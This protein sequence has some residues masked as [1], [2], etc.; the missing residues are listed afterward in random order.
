MK[1]PLFS[2]GILSIILLIIVCLTIGISYQDTLIIIIISGVV[3]FLLNI[4]K[5]YY[6]NYQNNNLEETD[7]NLE[8][9]MPLVNDPLAS[10]SNK[11]I[12]HEDINKE[13]LKLE[14]TGQE[15]NLATT[16]N[17]K[18]YHLTNTPD[19]IMDAET[20]NLEDC[21]TDKT[22]VQKPDE[23]N[24][25]PG[26]DAED[27]YV[28]PKVEVK[29]VKDEIKG[30]VNVKD[31]LVVEN[32]ENCPLEL[33]GVVKPFN[34]AVI[35]PY[36]NYTMEEEIEYQED[37]YLSSQDIGDN[38]CFNCKIGHCQGG[39][40]RDINEL[41]TEELENIVSDINEIKNVHPF[42]KNFPTILA[43][44]PDANY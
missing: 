10:I 40:C 38:I 32:F 41:K 31:K 24:L 1:L 15:N 43:T 18:P 17:K 27:T 25:F 36:K 12:N 5:V 33:N 30:D 42:S 6:Y 19:N 2:Q 4:G 7:L 11:I 14:N 39:I 3:M 9:E 37:K 34:N 8:L 21:T 20:Y 28:S 44:N 29:I 22:C 35:N 23:K 26:F 13:T 16:E